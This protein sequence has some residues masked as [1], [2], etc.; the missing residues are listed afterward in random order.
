MRGNKYLTLS[1]E[2]VRI[3]FWFSPVVAMAV[4]HPPCPTN[5]PLSFKVSPILEYQREV[6]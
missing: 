2:A 5:S 4:T 3:M 6:N 1:L